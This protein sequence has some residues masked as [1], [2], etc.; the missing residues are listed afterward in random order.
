MCS[1]QQQKD[2][3]SGASERRSVKIEIPDHTSVLLWSDD[4]F[5]WAAVGWIVGP[6]AQRDIELLF[7]RVLNGGGL[8]AIRLAKYLNM[9]G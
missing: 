1:E 6:L 7:E 3:I 8:D 9:R 5:W 2:L 4:P